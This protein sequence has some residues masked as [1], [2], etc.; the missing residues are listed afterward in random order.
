MMDYYVLVFLFDHNKILKLV[1]VVWL[2]FVVTTS[3]SFEA[4][5]VTQPA[6]AH[7]FHAAGIGMFNQQ[8][9]WLVSGFIPASTQVA[10]QGSKQKHTTHHHSNSKK[11]AARAQV[12]R[13]TLYYFVTFSH[14]WY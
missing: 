10:S 9:M 2:L 3:K 14:H 11:R 1:L 4:T 8:S 12:E 13:T 7:S 6:F 5:I